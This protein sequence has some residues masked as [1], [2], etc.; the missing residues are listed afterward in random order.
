MNEVFF[1]QN[2]ARHSWLPESVLIFQIAHFMKI[3]F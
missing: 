2:L 1:D 3:S